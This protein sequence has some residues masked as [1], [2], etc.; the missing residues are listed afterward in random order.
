M[1]EK[2]KV[3][4]EKE[5]AKKSMHF[6]YQENELVD[7]DYRAQY[8][9]EGGTKFKGDVKVPKNSFSDSA[10]GYTDYEKPKDVSRGPATEEQ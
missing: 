4:V 3:I 5:R 1:S 7:K 9:K 2:G 8:L 10:E 6:P